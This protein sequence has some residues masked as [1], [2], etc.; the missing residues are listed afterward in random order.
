MVVVPSVFDV[1]TEIGTGKYEVRV[2]I[3]MIET[4]SV[5]SANMAQKRPVSTVTLKF[6]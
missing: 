6:K 4:K 3:G 5:Y 1:E 2:H